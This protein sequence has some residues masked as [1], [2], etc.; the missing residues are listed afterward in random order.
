MRGLITFAL[1]AALATP[2]NADK[3]DSPKNQ[4]GD[5]FEDRIEPFKPKKARS[6]TETDLV[7]SAAYFAQGRV[8]FQR[9]DLPGALR[10]YQR[11]YRYDP[12]FTD[13]LGDI[14]SISFRLNHQ[15]EAYEYAALAAEK[16]SNRRQLV[17]GMAQYLAD[18]NKLDRA[19]AL[20]RKGLTLPKGK[21][22]TQMRILAVHLEVGRLCFLA[23]RYK[24]SGKHFDEFR[25]VYE[26]KSLRK[27]QRDR[28]LRRPSRTYTMFGLA[29]L[30]AKRFVDAEKMFRKVNELS[31]SE[32][33]LAYH[34]ARVAT[35]KK[36]YKTARKWLNEYMD[37]KATISGNSPYQL[38]DQVLQATLKDKKKAQKEF[39]STLAKAHSE[40]PKNDDL[41]LLLAARQFTANQ[42]KSAGKL[43][44]KLLA[45]QRKETAREGLL[46]VA[47]KQKDV[48]VLLEQL[49][50]SVVTNKGFRSLSLSGRMVARDKK[51][52]AE[53]IK[54]A[55][56]KKGDS[57]NAKLWTPL[58]IGLLALEAKQL[59]QAQPFLQVAVK[60][61]KAPKAELLISWA[62]SLMTKT[63]AKQAIPLLQRVLDEKLR[64]KNAP[65]I[66][67]QL[68]N[69]YYL[70]GDRKRALKLAK[71]AAAMDPRNVTLRTDYASVLYRIRE[72]KEAEKEYQ[73]LLTLYDKDHRTS[74]NRAVVRQARLVLSTICVMTD[75]MQEAEEWLEQVLDEF[76]EH[77]G[78]A[79][80]LGYLW[81]DQGKHLERSLRMVKY[82]VGA[83]PRNAAYR[84]SL[85][86]AYYR[87][88]QYK[89]AAKQLEQAVKLSGSSP[90]AVILDHLGDAYRK[91]GN[92][93]KAKSTYQKAVKAFD[94][95]EKDKKSATQTKIKQ[96]K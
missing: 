2:V 51:L 69:A 31:R 76:P 40:Q 33:R 11:A 71:R 82:A 13:I 35:A 48:P 85:G 94:D 39:L 96:L 81:C 8:L 65:A 16:S 6:E 22:D 32:G 55:K 63:H 74:Q 37:L 17:M 7:S 86:W 59:D 41:G 73:Q 27:S 23:K 25:K 52:V 57:D 83:E 43:F 93:K 79:N 28:L 45:G 80:D 72:L 68:A 14:V 46:Q 64:P 19:I 92:K 61:A 20:Y 34:L 49:T 29:Y 42:L 91:L 62:I 89:Q 90:D 12:T 9:G 10:A 15:F 78:A 38:L 1:I 60:H 47:T 56:T 87:L 24:D 30:E 36:D 66:Q 70:I 21:Q 95:S 54:L 77:V 88:G 53:L 50:Q 18:Q 58:A 44:R 75:R 67:L 84:D 26:S 3:K 5:S 4:K